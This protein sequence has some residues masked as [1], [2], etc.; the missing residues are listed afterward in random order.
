MKS[1]PEGPWAL[2]LQTSTWDQ[3]GRDSLSEPCQG[4][5][6]H[7][8]FCNGFP[9]PS[10]DIVGLVC[11]H[12]RLRL[13]LSTLVHAPA[14]H[15]CF[16]EAGIPNMRCDSTTW[17]PTAWIKP[18]T[19]IIHKHYK[20][21][22]FITGQGAGSSPAHGTWAQ[23]APQIQTGVVWVFPS[24]VCFWPMKGPVKISALEED[25]VIPQ[26][27]TWDANRRNKLAHD[28]VLTICWWNSWGPVVFTKIKNACQALNVI[29]LLFPLQFQPL[30][31][32]FFSQKSMALEKMWQ[33]MFRMK[34]IWKGQAINIVHFPLS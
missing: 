8:E 20:E 13:F 25:N 32:L 9:H 30:H 31:F 6:R 3:K 28:P 1:Q 22:W 26:F 29:A 16:L 23:T 14:F 11:N 24:F 21:Q 12:L 4:G 2:H 19:V 27:V 18:Q 7:P 15:S 5:W 10:E 33:K 17:I 34:N